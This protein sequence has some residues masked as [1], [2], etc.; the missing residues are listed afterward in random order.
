MDQLTD[1]IT[2]LADDISDK[3]L[4]ELVLPCQIC[5]YILVIYGVKVKWNVCHAKYQPILTWLTSIICCF[6]GGIMVK[7]LTAQQPLTCFEDNDAV[8]YVTV[9]WIIIFYCPTDHIERAMCN[10]AVVSILSLLKE[11]L[12]AKKVQKSVAI[13][14]ATYSGSLLNPVLL[15]VVGSCG[16]SFLKNSASLVTNQWNTNSITMYTTSYVTKTCFI[17][18][19]FHLVHTH[20]WLDGDLF[21]HNMIALVQISLIYTTIVA[22]KM[23]VKFNAFDTI[24]V[25]LKKVFITLPKRIKK[26]IEA[27]MNPSPN[28]TCIG[29]CDSKKRTKASHTPKMKADSACESSSESSSCE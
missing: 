20:G 19:F 9:L 18:S 3:T 25:G 22:Q 14:Y 17:S 28:G 8:M 11:L 21:S 7:M 1:M 5:H 16:G 10:V 23:G 26:K 29:N 2:R 27:M 13:G 15:G 6:G 4:N 12:R 24:E